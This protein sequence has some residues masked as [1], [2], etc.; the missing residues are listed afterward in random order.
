MYRL[1]AGA[2]L[3]WGLG[4]NDAANVFG[5]G[6]MTGVVRYRTAVILT[7]VFVIISSYFEGHGGI[8]TYGKLVGM[9]IT[10]AFTAT[11]AAA[12]TINVFTVLS[13]PASTSQAIVGS[14]LAIGLTNGTLDPGVFL[15]IAMSWVASPVCAAAFSYFFYRLLGSLVEP[16]IQNIRVWSSVIKAGFYLAGVYGAYTLGANNVA[17]T[18]AVF[19]EAGLVEP[20][21]ALIVGGGGI[22]LGV[23]TYSKRVMNTVGSRITGM[24]ELAGLV[25]V[26]SMDITVHLFTWIGVP[27]SNTQAIVGSVV[28]VGLVKTSK[29]IDRRLLGRIGV[30]WVSTPLLAMIL[31]LLFTRV[32]AFFR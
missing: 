5:T 27:V 17:N 31:T 18:T 13:L 10:G 21:T 11:L 12:I 29:Q 15:K 8:E 30:G 28:G 4:A 23:L 22:A 7:A 25:A 14:I 6:V 3:G 1:L 9:D 24:S 20:G 2:Y 16:R 19:V 26:L 32:F